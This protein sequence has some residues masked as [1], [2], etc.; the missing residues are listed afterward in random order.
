MGPTEFSFIRKMLLKLP[1]R[2]TVGGGPRCFYAELQSRRSS[3]S[4]QNHEVGCFKQL[5]CTL[6]F[7]ALEHDWLLHLLLQVGCQT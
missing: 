5:K 2:E 1:I 6:G 7:G 3:V 4:G